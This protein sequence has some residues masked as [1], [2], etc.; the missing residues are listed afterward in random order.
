MGLFT[1]AGLAA[2]VAGCS[3]IYLASENQRWRA[4]PLPRTPGRVAGVLLLAIAWQALARDAQGIT[5]TF[6]LVTAAML[7]FAVLPY[8]GAIRHARRKP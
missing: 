8:L 5:A 7:A 3:C 4:Q 2:T 1:L 6:V